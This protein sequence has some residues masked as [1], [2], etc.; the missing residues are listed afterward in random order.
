MSDLID[1]FSGEVE[2]RPKINIHRWM[3]IQRLYAFGEWTRT[4]ISTGFDLQGS[5]V[6]QAVQLADNIDA[7]VG[8]SNKALYILRIESI[9]MC[10]EDRQDT[11]YHTN[12][13]VNKAKVYEDMQIVG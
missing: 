3:G 12:G 10:L 1:R 8:A 4:D 9:C 11:F 7:Q 5:E 6:T 13:V 2:N